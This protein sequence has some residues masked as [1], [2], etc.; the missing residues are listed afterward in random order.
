VE[1][2]I[3]ELAPNADLHFERV[4]VTRDQIDEMDLPTRPTKKSDS[5]AKNFEGDSVEVDAIEP[6]I[7]REM[8]EQCVVQH[9]D[10]DAYDR[11]VHLRSFGFRCKRIDYP[12]AAD[13]QSQTEALAK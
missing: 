3:R 9:V 13:N 6:D 5:R 2:G 8:A 1:E 12:K 7:L 10:Q 11:M 4:A